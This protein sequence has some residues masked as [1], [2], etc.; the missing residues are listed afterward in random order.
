MK[1]TIIGAGLIGVLSAYYLRKSG[2]DVVV[3][4][5][6]PDVG[7]ET[8]FA[9]GG[10]ISVSYSEPWA[11]ISNLKKLVSWLGN[12][13]SPILF[14]FLNDVHHLKW[15]M[16]FLYQCLPFNNRNNIHDMIELAKFS[17]ESLQ[18]L[19]SELNL[20]HSSFNKGILTIY[21]NPSDVG[22]AEA[23][24]DFAN[25]FGAN[26][27]FKNAEECYEIEPS[28]KNSQVKVFGGD[29]TPDDETGDAFLFLLD[30]KAKCLEMGI[31]FIFDTP[32]DGFTIFGDKIKSAH[33]T[34]LGKVFES[35]LFLVAAGSYSYELFKSLDVRV[36][37][38]PVKGY[39]ISIPIEDDAKIN[40]VSVSYNEKKTVFT[41]LGNVLRVAGTAEFAG[42][43]ATVDK[44]KKRTDMLL[45]YA[46]ELFPE[47]LNYDEVYRWA[48][49]RPTTTNGMP[50]TKQLKYQNLFINAG[51]GTLGWTMAA[52]SGR[53]IADV[54][55]D[56]TQ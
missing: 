15:N 23:A 13:E 9:N 18:E 12:E 1:I 52:G 3:I 20:K 31:E 21:T 53:R 32:I 40:N 41:K 4:D 46:K 48:G 54:V 56:Y 14:R 22:T 7:M 43:D 2:F 8:S 42:F 35:D 6:Q 55:K 33:S 30:L 50:L 26:R 44:S 49:L 16:S 36:P 27:Y 10:Q 24:I 39:S 29:Y 25:K 11:S 45:K 38:V 17:R 34:D 28:L 47:G 5:R 19:R 51:H 37:I